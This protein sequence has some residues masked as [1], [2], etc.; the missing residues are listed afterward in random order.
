[1][2]FIVH[3]WGLTFFCKCGIV[4]LPRTIL[5]VREQERIFRMKINPIS[6]LMRAVF[7]LSLIVIGTSLASPVQA[8]RSP[9]VDASGRL[10]I[11]LN[12]DFDFATSITAY[13]YR[14]TVDSFEATEALDDPASTKCGLNPGLA[15][16]W[17]T[18]TPTANV[19]VHMDTIGSNYDTYMAVWTGARGSLTELACND[20]AST[21]E[22]ASAIDIL[23]TA[24]TTYYIEVAQFNGTPADAKIVGAKILPESAATTATHVF[25]L[26]PLITRIY[27]SN[28]THDGFVV[29]SQ[30]NS[31]VGLIKDSSLAY[32]KIGDDEK[33]R[34]NLAIVSFNTSALPNTAIVRLALIKLKLDRI[35]GQSTI[36]TAFGGLRV[37]IRKPYFGAGLVLESSD[38]QAAASQ[39][40]VGR[41]GTVPVS[42]W[43]NARLGVTSFQYVNLTGY[44]QFRLRFYKDDDNDLVADYVRFHSGNSIAAH[45][46]ILV[47]RY[48][49]P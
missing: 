15:T 9:S 28:G 2:K 13:P 1:M 41:F 5:C 48:Y 11:A 46:P 3:R 49:L 47:I 14:I 40:L 10:V 35:V 27:R 18:Y 17:Y 21:T 29:E 4:K 22:F 42:G 16:V 31:K 32:L 8:L 37:D 23:L 45:T 43:Y 38:F 7:L 20:D 6:P 36:F 44:T 26:V 19:L 25:R 30:E 12:D 34:Q 24:G 39:P 33:K